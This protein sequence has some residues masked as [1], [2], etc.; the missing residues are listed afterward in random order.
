[1]TSLPQESFGDNL[2]FSFEESTLSLGR[3][4]DVISAFEEV[5]YD[6]IDKDVTGGDVMPGVVMPGDVMPGVVMVTDGDSIDD[7]LC[8][9]AMVVMVTEVTGGNVIVLA[10][11]LADVKITDARVTADGNME[12]SDVVSGGVIDSDVTVANE[13]G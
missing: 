7:V 9:D 2:L 3:N 1:L 5:G 4:V 6:I 12:G 13:D 10:L 11:T 8:A